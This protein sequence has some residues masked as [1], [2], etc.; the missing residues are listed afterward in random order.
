ME[1]IFKIDLTL[2]SNGFYDC[3]MEN[4]YFHGSIM[5]QT[6]TSVEGLPAAGDDPGHLDTIENDE[7]AYSYQELKELFEESAWSTHVRLDQDDAR[8]QE[9]RTLSPP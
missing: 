5:A 2:Y 6:Y 4:S 9:T 3:C 7:M 8:R 1:R